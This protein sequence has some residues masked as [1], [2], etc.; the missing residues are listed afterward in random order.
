MGEVLLVMLP[1]L[2][3]AAVLWAVT[4]ALKPRNFGISDAE[5]YQQELAA[6]SQAHYAAQVQ[7]AIDSRAR[8]EATTRPRRNPQQ[9]AQ[10]EPQ[11]TDHAGAAL[12]ARSLSGPG[13]T[14][15][16]HEEAL[17]AM[18]HLSP[19]LVLQLQSLARGGHKTKAARL[20]RQSTHTD[21]KTA[22]NYVD[23]L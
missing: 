11:Q 5:R 10:Q 6:K 19:Q 14:R 17:L 4:T 15:P 1:A 7:A 3:L 2:I 18:G 22:K 16:S 9:E 8:I 13:R 20:L 23:R 21:H 12:L